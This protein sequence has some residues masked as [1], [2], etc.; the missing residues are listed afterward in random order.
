MS[1]TQ[2]FRM[3]LAQ[4][5]A[6]RAPSCAGYFYNGS[7]PKWK[8]WKTVFRRP[9][10][11]DPARRL[12]HLEA[13]HGLRVLDC[14]PALTHRGWYVD[15][16]ESE[17]TKPALILLSHGRAIA[18]A[19]D[20]WNDDA[21][22]LFRGEIM[23]KMDPRGNT[24]HLQGFTVKRDAI[25]RADRCTELLAED[26]RDDDQ[27]QT[28]L[29]DLEEARD[30]IKQAEEDHAEHLATLRAR[31]EERAQTVHEL[32]EESQ[33]ENV[34]NYPRTLARV[35]RALEEARR[36]LQIARDVLARNEAITNPAE[37]ERE[38]AQQLEEETA[39]PPRFNYF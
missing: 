11:T 5:K 32:E 28:K 38:A 31:V 1:E 6:H 4:R 15:Q 33:A 26:Y 35:Q 39:R 13:G 22:T 34:A 30:A 29:H 20:P 10:G 24:V 9:T 23:D 21:F 8:G 2:Y 25:L 16:H 18:A 37:E 14:T 3:S 36:D 17:T 19:T 7:N 12:A 27:H